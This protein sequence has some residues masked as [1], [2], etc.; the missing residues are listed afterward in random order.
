MDET[1]PIVFYDVAIDNR[2][3]ATQDDFDRLFLAMARAVARIDRLESELRNARPTLSSTLNVQSPN[4]P[5]VDAIKVMRRG[6][7]IP[8]GFPANALRAGD[9]I[10]R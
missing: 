7:I 1:M 8:L 4:G 2:R 5:N 3:E 6:P 10:P 9:G